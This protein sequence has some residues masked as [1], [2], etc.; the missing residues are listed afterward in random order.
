MKYKYIEVWEGQN[1]YVQS[2]EA[3]TVP[4]AMYLLKIKYK[5]MMLGWGHIDENFSYGPDY[6]LILPENTVNLK[7][8]SSLELHDILKQHKLEK[9][10]K[11]IKEATE[12]F[13][14][15]WEIYQELKRKFE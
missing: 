13:L 8:F 14:K 12:K 1:P 15:E 4:H 5:E 3:N 11:N 10:E 6:S 2:I 7:T 9:A